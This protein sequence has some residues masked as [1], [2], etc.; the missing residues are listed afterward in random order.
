MSGQ[1]VPHF[2]GLSLFYIYPG[3]LVLFVFVVLYF[4]H[5]VEVEFVVIG[6][7]AYWDD[8]WY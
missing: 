4:L 5:V 1:V 2:V 6:W 8:P 7:L 3:G